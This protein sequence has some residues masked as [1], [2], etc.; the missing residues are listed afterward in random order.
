M[1]KAIGIN[2]SISQFELYLSKES[3]KVGIFVFK[4][5]DTF[6]SNFTLDTQY[7][8]NR[9]IKTKH[10]EGNTLQSPAFNPMIP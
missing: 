1:T 10:Y 4:F 2:I 8:I 6:S 9:T 5:Q 7:S 3:G